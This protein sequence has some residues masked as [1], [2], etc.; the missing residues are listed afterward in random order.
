MGGKAVIRKPKTLE[1][2]ISIAKDFVERFDYAMPLVVDSLENRADEA[3]AA[4][5]ARLYVIDEQ[6]LVAYKGGVGPFGFQPDELEQWLGAR[7][8]PAR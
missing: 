8:G 5:P 3:Y 2:R 4:W 6:G 7:F 1:Q